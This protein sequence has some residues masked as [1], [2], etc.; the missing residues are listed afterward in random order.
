V[1]LSRSRCEELLQ[2]SERAVLATRHE[3]RGVDAVPVCFVVD[4]TRVAVPVDL[5]K[6][7]SSP[8]LQRNRNLDHDPRAALL[9]DHWDDDWSRLW[10][11]RAS[12]TRIA[13]VAG[14]RAELESQLALKYRQY[15]H[16]PFADLTVFEITELTGWSAEDGPAVPT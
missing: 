13:A 14:E 9:C 1:R 2:V 12:V 5:I 3:D 11:V 8:L 4:G 16:R 7:K 10:W 6:P 15:R